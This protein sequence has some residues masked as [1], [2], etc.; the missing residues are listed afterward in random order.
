MNVTVDTLSSQS[1]Q[2]LW[3]GLGGRQKS[4]S[5]RGIAQGQQPITGDIGHPTAHERTLSLMQIPLGHA[6]I[7]PD[8]QESQHA[9]REAAMHRQVGTQDRVPVLDRTTGA[10]SLIPSQQHRLGD[11]DASQPARLA[12]GPG[13]WDPEWL[14]VAT[15]RPAETRPLLPAVGKRHPAVH[16]RL[17][18]RAAGVAKRPAAASASASARAAYRHELPDSTHQARFGST[19]AASR[20]TINRACATSAAGVFNPYMAVPCV[21]PKYVLQVR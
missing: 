20:I 2:R 15:P 18:Q 7:M 19:Q 8:G 17:G 4:R 14:A 12:A 3:L 1:Q 13:W 5:L 9:C 10:H 16:P 21:C 11:G 6:V